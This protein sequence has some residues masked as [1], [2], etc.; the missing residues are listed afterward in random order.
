MG[1]I[2]KRDTTCKHAAGPGQ[3]P[4][5][6]LSGQAKIHVVSQALSCPTSIHRSNSNG[7][8]RAGTSV[9]VS[10]LIPIQHGWHAI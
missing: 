8:V 6:S 5:H 4:V 7:R 2:I 3:I 9:V 1:T 10:R